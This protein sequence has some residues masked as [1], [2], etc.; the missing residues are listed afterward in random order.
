MSIRISKNVV[1][2]ASAAAMAAL[3][4]TSAVKHF[5]DPKFYYTVVPKYLCSDAELPEGQTSKSPLAVLSRDGWVSASGWAEAAA[6]VG[7][8]IPGTRRASA[9]A[10]ASMFTAFIAGHVYALERA[11]GPRGSAKERK[12]HTVRLPLQLPLIA[13]A[14]SLR[15]RV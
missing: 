2:H 6:A 14:W 11:Y 4:L 1:Q 3:L 15:R 7:L 9:T 12:F 5:R 13:W 8:L 10:T